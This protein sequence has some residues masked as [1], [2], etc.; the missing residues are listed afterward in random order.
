M[1]YH[2]VSP[3]PVVIPASCGIIV[4]IA[5]SYAVAFRFEKSFLC[6]KIIIGKSKFYEVEILIF[7]FLLRVRLLFTED[8]IELQIPK[9]SR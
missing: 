9:R 1:V 5:T 2:F 4:F 6:L 3:S 8:G 7:M